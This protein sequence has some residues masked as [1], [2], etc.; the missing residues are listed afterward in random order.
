[1]NLAVAR[2]LID[3]NTLTDDD[4]SILILKAQKEALNHYFWKMDDI[5]TEKQKA[6]FCEK[7]EYEIYDIARAM[8]SDAARDGLTSHTELGVSRTWGES[9]RESVDKALATIPK[10]AYVI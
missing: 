9:G 10:K 5:P 2:V 7:Y 6:A 1:M 8:N 4:L 3:D